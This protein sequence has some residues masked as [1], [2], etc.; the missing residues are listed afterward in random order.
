M[1]DMLWQQRLGLAQPSHLCCWQGLYGV[2]SCVVK[3]RTLEFGIR[4]L[5]RDP[6][7]TAR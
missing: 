3:Q 6:R 5:W 4:W 1:L 2:I 7:D